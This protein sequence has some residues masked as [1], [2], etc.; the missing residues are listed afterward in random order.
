MKFVFTLKHLVINYFFKKDDE[1]RTKIE[2]IF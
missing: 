2:L 1:K